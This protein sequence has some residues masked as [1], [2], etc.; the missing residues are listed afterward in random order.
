VPGLSDL[1][2]IA[3]LTKALPLPVNIMVAKGADIGALA[4]HRVARVS[5]GADPYAKAMNAFQEA[6]RKA[7][8][9]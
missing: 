8:P 6:A 9:R 5:Y 3:E 2:L 1:G 7:I 4:K